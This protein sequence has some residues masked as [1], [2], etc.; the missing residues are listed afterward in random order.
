MRTETQFQSVYKQ[1]EWF[2]RY[3]NKPIWLVPSEKKYEI[4]IIKPT[5]SQLPRG[6]SAVLYNQKM[7]IIDK[8]DNY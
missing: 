2:T 8:V 3:H 6:T 1:A 4:S 5:S 7:D